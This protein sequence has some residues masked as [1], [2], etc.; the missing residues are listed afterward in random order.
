M[1]L[2]NCKPKILIEED[3]VNIFY[4]LKF[5]DIEIDNKD[6]DQHQKPMQYQSISP[7]HNLSTYQ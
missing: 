6:N 4:H 2:L 5:I 7:N 3:H 1:N